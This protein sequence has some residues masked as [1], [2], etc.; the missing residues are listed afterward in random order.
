MLSAQRL[1]DCL[2]GVPEPA[3]GAC[4]AQLQ[5]SDW[6]G[7]VVSARKHGLRPL[8]YERLTS[9]TSE[10]KIPAAVLSAL[11]EAY[12][13]NGV[14]NALLYQ[15]LG[16][17][18]GVFREKG[19]A[20]IVLKGAHLAQSV[21]KT[22][23]SRQMVDIDLLVKPTDLAKAV[24]ALVESGYSS[25]PVPGDIET[26]CNQ[27]RGSHH[28]PSFAKPHHPRLELH[29]AMSP[30][31]NPSEAPD[32]WGESRS[33]VIAGVEA[34]VLSPE[35]VLIQLCLHCLLHRFRQGLRP[36]CDLA[37]ALDYYRGEL[38]W[39]E[40]L[41][42]ARAW[43]AEQSVHLG[44]WLVK[45]LMHAPVPESLLTKL[46]PNG[47]EARWAELAVETVLAGED[48]SQETAYALLLE[49]L[50]LKWGGA[51]SLRGK[52]KFLRWSMFPCRAS[53]SRY[54]A[55][56]HALPL[57]PLRNYTCYGTRA[58][59][60]LGASVRVAWNQISRGQESE[61]AR[62]LR[63]DGWLDRAAS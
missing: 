14:R 39:D 55:E 27:H 53:M 18:L 30:P 52:V 48:L 60:F 23:A 63:W 2:G 26:W 11:R 59:D 1:L 13:V 54:M 10:A 22:I 41:S 43:Q 8:L 42:R 44:L 33:A 61:T 19:V 62:R 47:L 24:G 37:A 58:I 25:E 9:A 5:N 35:D 31:P 29:W 50:R 16:K 21:Y 28:L 17:V 49:Y 34:R 15:D 6:Q 32:V 57:S 20:V 40:V 56:K 46:H 51:A 7:V 38:D 12:L 36:M 3:R 45:R 4:C